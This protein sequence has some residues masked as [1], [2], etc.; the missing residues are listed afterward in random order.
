M[1]LEHRKIIITSPQSKVKGRKLS[2]ILFRRRLQILGVSGVVMSVAS[3]LALS[4]K[5]TYQ[6]TIQILVNSKLNEGVRSSHTQQGAESNFTNTNLDIINDMTQQKLMLSS[7]LIQKAVNLLRFEYPDLT[8]EHIK[9]NKGQQAALVV[10]PLQAQTGDNKVMNQ[11]FEVSFKDNDPVRAEKVL[12]SLQK[13]YQEDNIE[14][15]KQSLSK[16]L[17]FLKKRLS[18]VKNKMIQADKNLEQFRKKNHLLD[19]QL[20]G[21]ILLESL[22]DITKQLRT[23]RAHL[24]DLQARYDNLKKQLSSL[25]KNAIVSFRLSQSTRYQTLLNEIQKTDLALAQ[26]RLRYTDNYPEVQKLIQQ[27]RTLAALLQEEIRRTLGDKDMQAISDTLFQKK[28]LDT[29]ISSGTQE[30]QQTTRQVGEADLKLMQDLT[31]VQTAIL[32]LRAN[33][34]SLA[35]SQEQI[36][37]E[38]S[39]YPSLIAQY[40]RLLPEVE[41]NRKTLEQLTAAQQSLGLMIAQGGSDFQVLEQ[42]QVENYLDSN[43]LSILLAGVLLAPILGIGTALISESKD[44]ISSPQ[45]LQRLTNL[46]LLGTVPQLSQLSTKKRSFRR[47]LRRVITH[48]S[49]QAISDEKHFNVYGLL[50][51]HE[52]LDMAYQNIHISKSCV[53]HKSVMVTSAMSGEGKSTLALGLAVSAARMHQRVLLIDANLR[54]PNLHKI[55]GLT[56]DWGLSLLLVEE[57]NSEVLEYIQPIHPSID[58]LTAGPTLEDTVKLLSSARMKELLEFFEQ[59]YDLVLIDTSPIL[60]TV[61]A[62]IL[63]SLCNQIVMV[64]RM[65]QVTC[66]KLI[67]ATE[68]LSNLNLIGIIANGTNW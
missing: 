60:G 38:L 21:K 36:R 29:E 33:E 7:N 41:T 40:N 58:V 62:T 68:I 44:V 35:D 34:K 50:P 54:Q 42:P 13:V 46:R 66:N 47:S 12:K 23:T 1:S 6:S 61:D 63:A 5:P 56:N 65:G 30:L 11:V 8:V 67:Q 9:G 51:S 64:G 39:K 20:Q 37:A 19:P 52:T 3:V 14:Q 4:A 22:A 2:T 27:R 55:L 49:S 16:G 45:E 59:T 57:R 31:Q 53:R 25:P 17:T 28:P 32:G 43:K 24:K 15:R 10:T 48:F 18:E 26:E